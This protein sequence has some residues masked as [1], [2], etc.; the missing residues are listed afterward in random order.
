M[1]EE[2]AT[3]L[4]SLTGLVSRAQAL[5]AEL[6]RL[7]DRVPPSF[8]PEQQPKYADV[9]FDFRYLKTTEAHEERV[10]SSAALLDLDDEFR[11]NNLPLVERFFTLFDRI[12]RW[13]ADFIRFL[14]DVDDGVYI[15]H[16]LEG[17]LADAD[18]KQL[19]VEAA[20]T[21]G[22]I[23]VL[24]DERFDPLL[25][26]RVVIAYYRHKGASDIPNIDD[27]IALCRRTGYDRLKPETRPK[28]YP[29]EYFARFALPRRFVESVV[30]R[31]RLDDVYN[32]IG[33]YPNPDHRSAALAQ[34]ASALYLVL[35]FAPDL[36]HDGVSV[37]REIVDKHYIDAF[38]VPYGAGHLADLTH[39]WANYDAARTALTNA[40][41]PRQVETHLT[42]LEA[43]MKPLAEELREYLADGVLTEEFVLN[44]IDGLLDALREANVSVRWLL[45]HGSAV[46]PAL[47]A[48]FSRRAPGPEAVIDVL[49]DTAELEM[50]MKVLYASLLEGKEGRWERSKSEAASRVAELAEF[51]GGGALSRNVKDDNLKS[52]FEHIAKEVEKL[53]YDEPLSAG[54]KVHQLVDALVDVEQFHQ[55]DTN[56]QTKQYLHDIREH[57]QRMVKTVNVAEFALNT[58]AVVSDASYAWGVIGQHTEYLQERIRRDSTMVKKQRS[59][60]LK[61][62]SILEMPLLRISQHRSDD[63]YSVTEYYSSELV[64]YV[65]SV[66]EVIPATMFEILNRIITVQTSQLKELPTRL[67]K[68]QLRDV[69]QLGE[70]FQLAEATHQVAVFTQGIL[71]M[72]RTFMGVIE[73]DPKKLLEDGIRKQ[74]VQ[75]ISEAFHKELVFTVKEVGL[76]G[77]IK[78]RDA[79]VDEFEARLAALAARLEGYRRSFEYIQDYV[80]IYGLRVWKEESSRIVA[81]NVE[82]ECN[83]FLKRGHV[84]DWQSAHQSVSVP[85]PVFP[86]TDAHSVNFTGRLAREILR[87]T[88]ARRASYVDAA[89]G[90]FDAGGGEIF[91]IRTFALL[92]DAVGVGGLAGL[93]R[94]LSFMT[95]RRLQTT[96]DL[97]REKMEGVAGD[98]LAALDDEL[99]PYS[100]L[101]D[102]GS[103]AYAACAERCEAADL[104]AEM[105]E[106]CEAVGQ[107][108]LLRRQ[109]LAELGASVGLDS[110]S[111]A[112]TLSNANDAALSDVRRRLREGDAS[113]EESQTLPELAR[114]LVAAGFHDPTLQIYVAAPAKAEWALLAFAFTLASLPLYRYDETVAA[115]APKKR[116]AA[117]DPTPTLV[118][119]LTF[120]RQFHVS[121]VSTYLRLMGQYLRATVVE[122]SVSAASGARVEAGFGEETR[123]CVAWMEAFCK[124]ADVSRGELASYAPAY[125]LDNAFTRVGPA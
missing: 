91:G 107:T 1:E 106:A 9:L 58:L 115:L 63:L 27:V 65:R 33:H 41:T 70:R 67:E 49:L 97:Y 20:A 8:V 110:H 74:L 42:K 98:A 104:F 46:N 72:E 124:H 3:A 10:E 35:Y 122:R 36:L 51:Y 109:L 2:N 101:P 18:G 13:H 111:L 78:T 40:V 76:L 54:R 112:S 116:G 64:A 45:L 71:A 39:V 62:K 117:G 82:Q 4:H 23:L 80:N 103:D 120:L 17:I 83:T 113:A 16:T 87:Q 34:Q 50:H 22:L 123:T 14:D 38:V 21:F 59:L 118:G 68:S 56:L 81:Y 7:S 84:Q 90:W 96:I 119:L 94:L 52:W 26:E 121:H 75:Q 61:L 31:L 47:R 24:L 102:A 60:F 100:G 44:N 11:E 5:V 114:H 57:L 77:G 105:R 69:A 12:V 93:D 37:M 89:S 92:R 15:Q 32:Q 48:V 66:L 99:R 86:P 125:V 19:T 85:I 43:R 28:G 73:L 108:Q 6:L 79:T 95:S 88:D 29:E 30:G 25:R 53:R 55:I